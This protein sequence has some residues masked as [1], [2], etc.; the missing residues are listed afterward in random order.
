MA[1]I[2]QA[3]GNVEEGH[4]TWLSNEGAA[5]VGES[6]GQGEDGVGWIFSANHVRRRGPFIAFGVSA[7]K[8]QS[9]VIG[10][11]RGEERVQ[12]FV[13]STVKDTPKSAI[14]NRDIGAN[15]EQLLVCMIDQ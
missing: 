6:C 12:V 4:S 11:A 8:E 15:A 13:K 1:T 14:I 7:E 5:R 3:G 9:I 10:N 2:V